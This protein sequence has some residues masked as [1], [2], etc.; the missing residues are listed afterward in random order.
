MP[1]LA[2]IPSIDEAVRLVQEHLLSPK[3][4]WTRQPVPSVARDDVLFSSDRYWE[5]STWQSHN[6]LL[7]EGLLR[8]AD[9]ALLVGRPD[10]AALFA[11]VGLTLGFKSVRQVAF[12]FREFLDSKGHILFAGRGPRNFGWSALPHPMT[13]SLERLQEILALTQATAA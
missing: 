11:H 12:D 9:Q 5:G 6:E 1:L 7:V 10:A 2:G 3:G 4:F 8:Y 13:V